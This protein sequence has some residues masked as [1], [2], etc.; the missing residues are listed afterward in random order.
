ML[1]CALDS[2]VHVEFL[3]DYFQQSIIVFATAG[4]LRDFRLTKSGIH[5]ERISVTLKH[6]VVTYG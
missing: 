3:H 6:T 2:S 1:N 5:L 4:A